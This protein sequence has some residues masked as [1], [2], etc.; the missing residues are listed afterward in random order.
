MG[1]WDRQ[2]WQQ[3]AFRLCGPWEGDVHLPCNGL[4]IITILQ[5]IFYHPHSRCK[6]ACLFGD[7]S[8]ERRGMQNDNLPCVFV[9]RAERDPRESSPVRDCMSFNCSICI[10]LLDVL[11]LGFIFI[12]KGLSAAQF[13]CNA[14]CFCCF[15]LRC[16]HL[17][18][19]MKR[20]VEEKPKSLDRHDRSEEIQYYLYCDE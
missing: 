4:N 12:I 8:S 13:W 17:S 20:L 11:S 5:S 18:G 1:G 9:V 3:G 16:I 7:E 14:S 6:R 19:S 2:T 15:M 10:F